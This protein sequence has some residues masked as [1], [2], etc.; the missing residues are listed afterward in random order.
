MGVN[1][2]ERNTNLYSDGLESYLIMG[3][4]PQCLFI[5]VFSW[6]SFFY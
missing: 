6:G 3:D 1:M 5:Q 4:W 2:I